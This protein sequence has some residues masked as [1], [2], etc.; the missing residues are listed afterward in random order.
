MP[1]IISFLNITV[2]GFCGHDA[3]IADAEHHRFACNIIDHA[4]GVLFGRVTYEMFENFWPDVL[5]NS[6]E[7]DSMV[8]FAKLINDLPKF[9]FSR[10][11]VEVSWNRSAI[12]KDNQESSIKSLK[13]DADG[14]LYV[15]GSPGLVSALTDKGLIDEYYFLVQPMMAGAGPRLFD[16]RQMIFRTNMKLIDTQTFDSGVMVMHYGV[17]K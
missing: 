14:D 6:N 9:V 13:E 3:V 4:G 7:S 16:T 2:D 11:L 8:A 15:L 12:V 1:K 5:K 10:S 17:K